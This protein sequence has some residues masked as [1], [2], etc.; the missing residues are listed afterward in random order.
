MLELGVEDEPILDV[1]LESTE[2]DIQFMQVLQK[3]AKWRTFGHHSKGIDIFGE[4]LATITEF[5]I[6]TWDIGMSVID[7]T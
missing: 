7:V 2:M 4:A 6:R 3:G 5:A 1:L